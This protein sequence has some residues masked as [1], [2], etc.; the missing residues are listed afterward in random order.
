MRI[1][2]SYD[3]RQCSCRPWKLPRMD[4]CAQH[5]PPNIRPCGEP[6]GL[7]HT[8]FLAVLRPS[9]RAICWQ[10]RQQPLQLLPCRLTTTDK[11]KGKCLSRIGCRNWEL[12]QSNTS[13]EI[14][15]LSEKFLLEVL[16]EGVYATCANHVY[17]VM[18]H[19]VTDKRYLWFALSSLWLLTQL[20]GRCR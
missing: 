18:H 1:P 8:R 13:D 5:R 4:G 17:V 3:A 19:R 14:D 11:P 12:R 9:Q 2:R 7:C 20:H 10:H 6:F 15:L 16:L